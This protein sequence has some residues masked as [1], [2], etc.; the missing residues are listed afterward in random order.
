MTRSLPPDVSALVRAGFLE[1]VEAGVFRRPTSEHRPRLPSRSGVAASTRPPGR[2][3]GLRPRAATAEGSEL[4]P[5]CGRNPWDEDV[6]SCRPK[7]VRGLTPP[8]HSW[9]LPTEE[10]PDPPGDDNRCACGAMP[11]GYHHWGCSLEVC[12]FAELHP[13]DGEQ[14]LHCGCYE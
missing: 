14:L 2:R 8:V 13:D 3:P 10:W 6:T 9:P 1:E 4:C 5:G 12:P 11:G 7:N